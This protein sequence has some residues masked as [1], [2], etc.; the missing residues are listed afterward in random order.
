MKSQSI[1]PYSIENVNGLAPLH[2]HQKE[3]VNCLN[4]YS[5][6]NVRYLKEEKL[7]TSKLEKVNK[8]FSKLM[9]GLF[10]KGIT[11][12]VLESFTS[13]EK[14]VITHIAEGLQTKEI[15]TELFISEH[16]VQTHRKNIY[17]KMSCNNISDIVKVSMLLDVLQPI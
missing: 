9:K 15:A 7:I 2:S 6:K 3:I 13:Q 10:N 1:R 14:K 5:E 16:T 12:E 8:S 11:L 17:K 4:L